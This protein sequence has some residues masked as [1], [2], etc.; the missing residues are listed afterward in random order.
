M[1]ENSDRKKKLEENCSHSPSRITRWQANPPQ[2]AAEKGA[3]KR[4]K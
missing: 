2:I 4:L 3:T 1:H